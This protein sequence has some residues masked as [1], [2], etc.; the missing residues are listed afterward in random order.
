VIAIDAATCRWPLRRQ[1]IDDKTYARGSL[2][3]DHEGRPE[4]G[5]LPD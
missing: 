4:S 2:V 1:G 3:Q 5:Q